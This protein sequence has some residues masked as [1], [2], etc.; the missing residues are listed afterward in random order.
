MLETKTANECLR[1][2]GN[3]FLENP[4]SSHVGYQERFTTNEVRIVEE[5][6]DRFLKR[7]VVEGEDEFTWPVHGLRLEE[8]RRKKTGWE[9]AADVV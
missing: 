8:I 9:C 7:Q 1:K 3:H 6:L 2:I 4:L 5:L